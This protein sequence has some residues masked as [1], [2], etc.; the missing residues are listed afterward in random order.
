MKY[1]H[2]ITDYNN[3]S[4]YEIE[5]IKQLVKIAKATNGEILTRSDVVHQVDCEM[6]EMRGHVD[7]VID[8][9]SSAVREL[10][11]ETHLKFKSKKAE[12]LIKAKFEELREDLE[13]RIDDSVN[14]GPNL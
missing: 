9:V 14:F 6:D 1:I 5:E 4:E 11:E 8:L 13:N 2:Y 7:D 3:L 12:K 10:F